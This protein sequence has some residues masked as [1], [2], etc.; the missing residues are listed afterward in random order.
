MSMGGS[1]FTRLVLLKFPTTFKGFIKGSSIVTASNLNFKVF[2]WLHIKV[3]VIGSIESVVSMKE[4]VTSMKDL[5][6]GK[7]KPKPQMFIGLHIGVDVTSF[8]EVIA[9]MKDMD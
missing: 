4:V 5:N 1:C 6:Q 3:D 7:G 9:S 2:I 8:I